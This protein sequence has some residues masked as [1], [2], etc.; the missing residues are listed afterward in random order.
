MSADVCF[1][2]ATCPGISEKYELD[3]AQTRDTARGEARWR[4][5]GRTQGR[6]NQ[7]E[8]PRAGRLGWMQDDGWG[9]QEQGEGPWRDRGQDKAEIALPGAQT[10]GHQLNCGEDSE[11]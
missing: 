5:K 4:R 2:H 3:G 6:C 10:A 8:E 11:A 7:D 1:R 9:V